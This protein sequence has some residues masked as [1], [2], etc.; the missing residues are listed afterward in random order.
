[1]RKERKKEKNR[2]KI[3]KSCFYKNSTISA[4]KFSTNP[5]LSANASSTIMIRPQQTKIVQT[6]GNITNNNSNNSSNNN[7]YVQ[8]NEFFF[9]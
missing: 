7:N 4:R 6:E 3:D 5:S 9:L 2:L 8:Q 1:M